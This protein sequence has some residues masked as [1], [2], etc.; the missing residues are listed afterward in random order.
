MENA[1]STESEHTD[2]KGRSRNIRGTWNFDGPFGT[3][4]TARHW[5][6]HH[7]PAIDLRC[8]GIRQMV[9]ASLGLRCMESASDP[10][11]TPP[12]CRRWWHL[13]FSMVN[14]GLGKA[15]NCGPQQLVVSHAQTAADRS[16]VCQAKVNSVHR[17]S[18]IWNRTR[19]AKQVTFFPS[20]AS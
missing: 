16:Q 8:L 13:G 18:G 4:S 3:T 11:E 14:S 19:T 9:C 15:G 17:N 7:P 1:V 20:D 5:P 10:R 6:S 2:S 12:G